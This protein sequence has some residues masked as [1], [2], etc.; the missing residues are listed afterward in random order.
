[1]ILSGGVVGSP[2]LLLLSGVGPAAHLR[3]VNVPL[4]HHLPGV[5]QN[6]QDHAATYGKKKKLSSTKTT[7][8]VVLFL[9]E[10]LCRSVMDC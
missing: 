2:H 6:L 4:V 3:D 9:N 8:G 5:G 7:F 10:I 1:V